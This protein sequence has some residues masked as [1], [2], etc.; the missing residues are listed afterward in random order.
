MTHSNDVVGR[1][2]ARA[3][4]VAS[5]KPKTHAVTRLVERYDLDVG[6]AVATYNR[7]Q[8]AILRGEAKLIQSRDNGSRVYVV[9]EDKRAFY[10][11]MKDCKTSKAKGSP[12]VP[13]IVTYLNSTM[14][15]ANYAD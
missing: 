10:P 5:N 12:T 2:V 8:R 9:V 1:A 14:V 11:A 6:A 4:K 3:L 13:L 7:H 15:F